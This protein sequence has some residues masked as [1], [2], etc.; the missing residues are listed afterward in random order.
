MA[1]NYID[2][3]FMDTFYDGND[4]FKGKMIALF[5]EKS[6]GYM[7]DINEHLEQKN[8][9]DLAAVAHKFKASIDFVGAR[10]FKEVVTEIERNAKD[11]GL[12]LVTDLVGSADAIWQEVISEL[13]TELSRLRPE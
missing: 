6:P 13:N 9:E 1:Y 11:G 4:D 3:D 10:K 5:I 8:L 7:N 2:I 12:E